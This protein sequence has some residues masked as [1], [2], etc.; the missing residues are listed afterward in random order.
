M[1]KQEFHLTP[2]RKLTAE[3]TKLLSRLHDFCKEQEIT[4]FAVDALACAAQLGERMLDENWTVAMTR[5]EYRRF[6]K[7][8][9]PSGYAFSKDHRGVVTF[10]HSDSKHSIF[11]DVYDALPAGLKEQNA[12]LK[13]LDELRKKGDAKALERLAT[14]YENDPS[15]QMIARLMSGKGAPMHRAVLY[16]IK[17][18]AFEDIK[19]C[20]PC[21]CSLWLASE[22]Q[23]IALQKREVLRQL[24]AFCTQQE[25]PYFAISK[26]EA[27][28]RLFGDIRPDYGRTAMEIG[29]LRHYFE[30]FAALAKN[31]PRF[32]VYTTERSGKNTGAV[33]ITLSE[34]VEEGQY[35]DAT[36]TALPYDYLPQ[37]EHLR[38]RF[39]ADTKKLNDEYNSSFSAD[40][41]RKKKLAPELFKQLTGRVIEYNDRQIDAPRYI[42]RVQCAQSKVLPCDHVFPLVRS[43]IADFE[44]NCPNNPY[45]WAENTNIDFNDTVNSHKA[46]LLKRLLKLCEDHKLECFA[47]AN[48][49][50]GMVTYGDYV[51]DK[52]NTNWDVALLRS[53]YEKLLVLLREKSEAYE[54]KLTES[55][56]E[57]GRYPYQT[58]L[59]S[60]PEVPW[61]DGALR[62]LPFDKIPEAYDTQYAFMRK[63]RN[64]NELY[65]AMLDRE[66]T[67]STSYNAKKLEK[68]YKKYGP[69]ALQKLYEQIDRLAQSYNDDA[70]THLYGRVAFE[71]SKFIPKDQLFPLVKGNVRDV[72]MNRPND[73]SV[74]TPVIDEAL[75]IQVTSIQQADLILIDKID[76]I[77]RK[78]DIGYFICGGSMLGYA[79]NGGI[80][81]WDDDI[82]V[83]MLRADYDRFMAEAGA[84]LDERFFLQTRQTDPEIPYLFSKLRLNN[85]EY[86]TNY[87]ERRA[88]HKGICL[89]IFPFDF[90]PNDPKEQEKFKKEVLALSAAHNRVVNNQMP[91]PIDPIKP[92]NNKERYYKLYGKAKRFYFRCQSLKKTQQ[93]YLD[94]ATS[95]NSKAE[96]LGLTTVASFVPSYT[97]IRLTD[98][99]PYQDVLFEGHRVKVPRRPDVFLTMQ[100][101]DYLQLPPKHNR[102]AHRLLRWSVDVKADEE[103][104]KAI[105]K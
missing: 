30:D 57:Q 28:S 36:I 17:N 91:E 51:P 8:A 12:Y 34:F 87:N 6:L 1:T 62:L 101:G 65:K 81:P 95:L 16:P 9:A 78:L 89:D 2:F 60:A 99:L 42:A 49:L 23:D 4:Y 7:L 59:L 104:E 10:T 76:E 35:S 18:R 72:Q 69:N 71:K 82:D 74:W 79:R 3:K 14:K 39:L 46:M 43:K 27:S 73:Y 5:S 84:Y 47:V 33:Y 24:D 38:K 44:I 13:E 103:K 86:I 61:P 40:R 11:V 64:M 63:L 22:D 75:H 25:I 102:V 85:T 90:I 100:Y 48:L 88:F 54:L 41:N 31:D 26:L 21:D 80:I 97:Y 58:K 77:C 50:I 68:G 94:K 70:Q 45:I 37:E 32:T 53:D 20:V 92:R 105:Q 15:A 93:A 52:P 66:L 55:F 96:E 67:G 29:V 98:L 19:V 56:D 83:A